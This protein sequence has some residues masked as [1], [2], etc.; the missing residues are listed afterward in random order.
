MS[1]DF[2]KHSEVQRKLS[3]VKKQDPRVETLVNEVI[4]RVADKWTMFILEVLAENGELRFTQLAK[5]VAGISQKMLTQT[6]REMEREGLVIRTVH[7]VIPPKVEYRLTDLGLGLGAAFCG[8]W[9]WAEKNLEIIEQARS[10]FDL[11]SKDS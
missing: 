5:K 7:P 9:V 6:L 8:V 3:S 10:A 2:A 11:R 1:I 4:G